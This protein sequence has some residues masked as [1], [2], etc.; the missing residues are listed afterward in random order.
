M[1]KIVLVC[2]YGLSTSLLVHSME[3]AAKEIGA[4]VQ[5]RA[6]GSSEVPDIA[7]ETDVFLVAPQVRYLLPTIHSHGRPAGVIEGRTYALADGAAAL[8][9]ALALLEQG[10]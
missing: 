3:S 8:R 4:P 1:N 6:V 9:Q 10:A 5:V 2:S 7:E